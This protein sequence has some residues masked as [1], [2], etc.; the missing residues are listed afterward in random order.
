MVERDSRGRKNSWTRHRTQTPC[1]YNA[2]LTHIHQLGKIHWPS[3]LEIHTELRCDLTKAHKQFEF[4]SNRVHQVTETMLHITQAVLDMMNPMLNK[5]SQV[6][7]QSQI[8][9]YKNA[10]YKRIEVHEVMYFFVL[11][12]CLLFFA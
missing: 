5:R 9:D 11:F 3:N 8:Y 6:Q 12:E 1:K 2:P 4:V 10:S 7:E